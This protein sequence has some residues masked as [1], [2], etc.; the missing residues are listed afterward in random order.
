MQPDIITTSAALEELCRRLQGEA[1][2]AVDLEADS[3]HHYRE[4]VCLIQIS[5]ARET[6]LV[7]PL[8]C[9]GLAPLGGILADPAV[10]KVMHGA[11]YDI[12]SFH[13]DFGFEVANLFDT[14]IAAQFLGETEIGLAALLRKRF[15]VELDKQYQKADWSRR[16]L[17]P[18]MIEYAAKDTAHLIDLYSQIE[19]L[20]KRLIALLPPEE[21]WTEEL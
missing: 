21:S 19:E 9:S 6:V 15:G 4:K 16:P 20:E 5:S 14:M 17:E 12:R 10:L 13:R 18:G 11:D 2:V 7:D 1:I 8:A 3:M